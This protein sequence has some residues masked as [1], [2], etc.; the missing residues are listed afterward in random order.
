MNSLI[1]A[2]I[3]HLER[4]VAQGCYKQPLTLQVDRQVIDASLDF[5]HRNRGC[6][7]ERFACT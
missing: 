1:L 5:R 6:E 4:V 2:Q 7:L 3:N